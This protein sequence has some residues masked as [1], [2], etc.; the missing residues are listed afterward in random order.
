M[1]F[2]FQ[3]LIKIYVCNDHK[4]SSFNNKNKNF[5][6]PLFNNS[7]IIPWGWLMLIEFENQRG[8]K[9]TFMLLYCAVL[10]QLFIHLLAPLIH[11]WYVSNVRFTEAIHWWLVEMKIIESVN[12]TNIP[13]TQTK[14]R[15][16]DQ[17]TMIKCR[18]GFFSI[19]FTYTWNFCR[20]NF[21]WKSN[22]T[23]Y[24]CSINKIMT[25]ICEEFFQFKFNHDFTSQ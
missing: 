14:Q 5:F 11:W 20:K 17:Q 25:M 9:M 3:T 8:G 10:I 15:H 23:S 24:K 6:S 22:K 4:I 19:L 16:S 2:S 7:I 1:K 18:D 21:R 13:C 12:F